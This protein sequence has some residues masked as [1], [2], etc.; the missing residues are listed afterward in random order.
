VQLG[1]DDPAVL[2]GV[3]VLDD[4]D[5]RRQHEHDHVRHVQL[6][7]QH[8]QHRLVQQLLHRQSKQNKTLNSEMG[9]VGAA[10]SAMPIRRRQLGVGT[11]RRM[12]N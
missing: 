12:A 4:G 7:T 9:R 1:L 11:I 8:R 2:L 6:L 10:D 5:E 3:G